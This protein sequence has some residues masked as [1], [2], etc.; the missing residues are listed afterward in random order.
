MGKVSSSNRPAFD[1]YRYLDQA[2]ALLASG[3]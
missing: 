2:N 3:K 1:P